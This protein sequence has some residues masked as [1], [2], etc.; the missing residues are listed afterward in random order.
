VT[1]FVRDAYKKITN[2]FMLD[3]SERYINER[4]RNKWGRICEY[5][6]EAYWFYE[7][8]GILV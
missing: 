5:Y 1:T 3:I 6:N 2:S 4:I 7:W 8:S